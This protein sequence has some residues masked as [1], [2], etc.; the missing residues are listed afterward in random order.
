MLSFWRR[1]VFFSRGRMIRAFARARPESSVGWAEWRV[2]KLD[3]QLYAACVC[4]LGTAA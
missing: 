4:V 1:C 2:G 3:G